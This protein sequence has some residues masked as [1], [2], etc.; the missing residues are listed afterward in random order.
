[1][2]IQMQ[3]VREM[4]AIESTKKFREMQVNEWRGSKAIA[5][6]SLC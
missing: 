6:T 1:M 5:V 2:E 3:N 4:L